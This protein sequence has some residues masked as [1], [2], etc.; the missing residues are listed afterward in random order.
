MTRASRLILGAVLVISAGCS[1]ATP[2]GP[3][4]EARTM[5]PDAG[6]SF[7]GTDDTCRGGWSTVNG[8]AC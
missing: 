2:T 4:R 1:Q 5:T 6:P 3:D 7:D 8:K